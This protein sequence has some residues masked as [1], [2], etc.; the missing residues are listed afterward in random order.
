MIDNIVMS[1]GKKGGKIVV[2]VQHVTYTDLSMLIAH[3]LKIDAV[4]SRTSRDIQI[5]HRIHPK[6]HEPNEI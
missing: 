4:Q 6:C 5:S 2:H 1:I 3:K